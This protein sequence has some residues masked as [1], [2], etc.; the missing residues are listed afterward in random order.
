MKKKIILIGLVLLLGIMIA[1]FYYR[2]NQDQLAPETKVSCEEYFGRYY[3]MHKEIGLQKAVSDIPR[4]NEI[5]S[6]AYSAWLLFS[7]SRKESDCDI[8]KDGRNDD[9][10]IYALGENLRLAREAILENNAPGVFTYWEEVE[11]E[12]LKLQNSSPK[13]LFNLEMREIYPDYVSLKQSANK[14]E[15][16]DALE[17]IKLSFA[18]LKQY[19][20]DQSYRD[21]LANMEAEIVKLDKFFDGPDYR[22]AKNRLQEI[23][24]DLYYRY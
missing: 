15:A 8:F 16:S 7:E 10:A 23:F 11:S 13:A 14:A 1:V 4:N 2:K 21:S 24:L 20:F 22:S 19:D 17:R 12:L 9:L 5:F 3:A 6:D 18:T